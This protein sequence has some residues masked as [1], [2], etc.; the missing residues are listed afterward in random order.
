M[1]MYSLLKVTEH[2]TGL[3]F[4]LLVWSLCFG[5]K[6]PN[7]HLGKH[8]TRISREEKYQVT[9]KLPSRNCIFF[10]E[11]CS[12]TEIKWFTCL[13]ILIFP[14]NFSLY[15]FVSSSFYLIIIIK[16]KIL[17]YSF[18]Q[19]TFS[20]ILVPECQFVSR[21]CLCIQQVWVPQK[22]ALLQ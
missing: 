7:E 12:S 16:I 10:L 14:Y 11:R 4:V 18:L 20:Q 1:W 17:F 15:F 5:T 8:P 21:L 13:G 19:A 22:S 6:S 3:I 9:I 2:W